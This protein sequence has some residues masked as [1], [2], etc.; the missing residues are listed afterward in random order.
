ML[1]R[2]TPIAFVF[3]LFIALGCS[4]KTNLGAANDA[5]VDAPLADAT[6]YPPLAAECDPIVPSH[7]GFPMP[8]NFATV[9]DATTKTGKR[10]VFKGGMIPAHNG[11]PT[12]PA[13]W[14]DLDGFSTGMNLITSLPNA[15]ITGLPTQDTIE[16]SL[17]KDSPTIVIDA[18]T[19]ERVPHFA[20]RDESSK[21][22]DEKAF[23]IRP[24]VRLKDA[25]R[26]IVAIRHVVDDGGRT[27]PASPAF[28]ALR[29]GKPFDH[30]SIEARRTLYKD[31]FDKLEKAGIPRADLQIAWDFTT[32][33]VDVQTKWLLHMRDDALATVGADGPAYTITKVDENPNPH[34]RRRIVGNMTVPLYL[35][36][37]T[38]G[39]KLVFGADGMPKQNGTADYEFVAWI[40]NA[41]T[42]GTKA[43]LVQNGH[44]L[45]GSKFEGGDDYL[46]TIADAENYVAFSVDFVGMAHDD[47]TTVT[48]TLVGDIGNFKN[49]VGRQHQGFVNELLAMRM[50]KGR[51]SK[52]PQ[53]MLAPDGSSVI[54]PTKCFYRGDS[55]G[56]IFGA[57]YM[58]ISTDVTR[59]LISVTGAPYSLLLNRSKDFKP[60]FFLLGT[61]YETS[62]DV[63]L[64]L[65]L[66]QMLWDRTEP[67]GYIAHMTSDPLPG[68]PAHQILI[69]AAIGD[70][71]VTPL[72]AEYI[73]RTVGAKLVA[74]YV[75]KVYG[76]EE[77]AAPF[78]GSGIV[79]FDFGLPEAP[80]TNVPPT[81]GEDPHELPRRRPEAYQQADA[82]FREGV[83][84]QFC[85]GPCAFK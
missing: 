31:I 71:Q 52:D 79:E 41:A 2:R 25:T 69:H 5:G 17:S 44:G 14:G 53:V 19:G 36:K 23:M 62:L 9:D 30:P 50:M 68:T 3:G 27:L 21:E 81:S 29:D 45:L 58:S 47:V 46:A 67:N 61:V 7:C 1:L 74:P 40:P 13:P 39:S 12:D 10:V 77:K 35:D 78:S 38:P 28:V 63:Q 64:A 4:S 32:A 8:S 20:E 70:Q 73:A 11:K 65:G 16:A 51:F 72:G 18:A 48:D 59:G 54:D 6:D 34:I 85:S 75:R 33:S 26:Y 66:T 49:V 37:A 42:K 55:Q 76:L 15:S 80:K 60:F 57:T 43:A 82:F 56:G 84:K 83:I 24:V 22:G